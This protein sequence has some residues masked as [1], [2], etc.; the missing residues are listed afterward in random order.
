MHNDNNHTQDIIAA[1]HQRGA[2]HACSRC[3][4]NQFSVLSESHLVVS[5]PGSAEAHGRIPLALVICENCGHIAQHSL[6][7]LGLA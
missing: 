7:V 5:A 6:K 4:Q 2:L 3:G 1:L